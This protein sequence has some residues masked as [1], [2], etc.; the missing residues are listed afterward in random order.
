MKTVTYKK[1]YYTS[2]YGRAVPDQASARIVETATQ[3]TTVPLAPV[4]TRIVRAPDEVWLLLPAGLLLI[5]WIAYL[6]L[7]PYDEDRFLNAS[8][9]SA[10]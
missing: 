10:G 1:I 4:A 5:T 6:V 8:T 7:E 2:A 3:P 9:K